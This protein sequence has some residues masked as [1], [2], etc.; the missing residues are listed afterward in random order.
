MYFRLKIQRASILIGSDIIIR[1]RNTRHV[2]AR[3][4]QLL[5][6]HLEQALRE[7]HRQREHVEQHEHDAEHLADEPDRTA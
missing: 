6:V 5:V 7:N 1:N 2:V 4:A 3:R